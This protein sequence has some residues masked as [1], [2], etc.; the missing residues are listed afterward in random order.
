ML[1]PPQRDAAWR[2]G[3]N[4]PRGDAGE[5]ADYQCGGREVRLLNYVSNNPLSLY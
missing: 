5:S 3:Y 4:T 1:T 2:A